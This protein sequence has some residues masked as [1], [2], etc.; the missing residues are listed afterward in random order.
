MNKNLQPIQILQDLVDNRKSGN[1]HI[2]SN[3]VTWEIYL[4]EGKLLYAYHS[5]QSLETIKHFL[6]SLNLKEIA[7]SLPKPSQGTIDSDQSVLSIINQLAAQ[8]ILTTVQRKILL[9][10]LSQDAMESFLWLTEGEC[11]W[12]PDN[13]LVSSNDATNIK[14]NPRD[15]PALLQQTL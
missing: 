5:F 6:L 12:N 11:Q 1:L 3:K 8:N 7:K 13:S 2:N 4:S 9:K 10:E 15:I 14:D